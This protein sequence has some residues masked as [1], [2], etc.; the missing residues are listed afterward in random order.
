MLSADDAPILV[1]AL[2]TFIMNSELVAND[3]VST[4]ATLS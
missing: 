3:I 4:V 2:H 1:P